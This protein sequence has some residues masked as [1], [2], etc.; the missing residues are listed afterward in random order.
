MRQLVGEDDAKKMRGGLSAEEEP[1]DAG[2]DQTIP[3]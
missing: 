2:I 3:P 1:D